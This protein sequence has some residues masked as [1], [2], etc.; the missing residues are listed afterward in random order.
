MRLRFFGDHLGPSSPELQALAHK[1]NEV[2]E[3]RVEDAF[4]QT[5]A[6]TTAGG[7]RSCA[8]PGNR[9]RLRGGRQ[10]TEENLERLFSTTWTPLASPIRSLSSAPAGSCG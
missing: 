8:R 9:C 10:M 1:A 7:M 3:H 6:S 5:C 2:A 4:R